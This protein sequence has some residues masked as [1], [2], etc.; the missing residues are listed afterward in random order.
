MNQTEFAVSRFENR[1]GVT[2]WRVAGWLHGVRIRKNFPTR[3]EAAAEKSTLEIKAA[4]TANGMR[5]V[6]TTLTKD[7]VREA[8]A[9]F[10]RMTALPRPLSFYVDFALGN[11]KEPEQQKP[12]VEATA[13]YIA[14][15]ESEFAQDQ[16]SIPQMERIRWE[17][18]RLTDFFP[19]KAVAELTSTKLIAFLEAGK[20][21]MKT[22]NNR[23][24]LLS[25][26]FKYCFQR[27]W[28]AENPIPKVPY[29]CIRRNT[30]SRAD[31]RLRPSQGTVGVRGNPYPARSPGA[32]SRYSRDG[33]VWR[34]AGAAPIRATR[35]GSFGR[36]PRDLQKPFGGRCDARW[37]P[38]HAHHQRRR[39]RNDGDEFDSRPRRELQALRQDRDA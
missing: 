1:N 38:G 13:E 4:Q 3:E 7:Q 39:R 20:G 25:T 30:Q 29:F 18:K 27:G 16:L 33:G 17:M 24:G 6:A 36:I 26:F 14:A 8:E 5:A 23:R 2:S 35:L 10:R 32:A 19:G 9:V 37:H 22:H 28:V 11:Y 12:L 34:P 15:K 21:G 31:P